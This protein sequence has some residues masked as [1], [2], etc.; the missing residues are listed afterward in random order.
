MPLR[1]GDFGTT[2][3]I[4]SRRAFLRYLSEKAHDLDLEQRKREQDETDR[5]AL[6]PSRAHAWAA[7]PTGPRTRRRRLSVNSLTNMTED[8][9]MALIAEMEKQHQQQQDESSA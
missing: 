9:L 7:A 8:A 5:Y 4:F 6:P 1:A 2:I 3:T